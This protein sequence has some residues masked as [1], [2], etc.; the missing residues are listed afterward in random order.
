MTST[1][2]H[3]ALPQLADACASASPDAGDPPAIARRALLHGTGA[4]IF[5]LGLPELA[6]GT[7]IVAVRVWP[8]ADYTRVTLESD[9]NLIGQH[10]VTAD[11]PRLVIDVD[12]LE[13]NNTLRELV[14]KVLPDDPHIARV[15]LGQSQPNRVRIVLDLKQVSRP[16][17]FA[18]APIAPYRHRLVFDLYP[19]AAPGAA[20]DAVAA[21]RPPLAAASP[22]ASSPGPAV[23]PLGSPRPPSPAGADTA[24]AASTPLRGGDATL[25][26]SDDD[27]MSLLAQQRG[28]GGPGA[29][30]ATDAASVYAQPGASSIASPIA[31]PITSPISPPLTP[32]A[33]S[34]GLDPSAPPRVDA[35]ATGRRRGP[36]P[37]PAAADPAATAQRA[38]PRRPVRPA[39]RL[40][41]VAIDPG[42]GGEDPGA[43]GPTGLREKDVVLAIGRQLA[44]RINAR[45]GMRAVLTRD[46][47]YFVPLFE[48]VRKARGA[49]ADLFMSIHADAFIRPH[50]RGASVFALS[51]SGASS[52]TARW[53]AQRENLS[54]AIGGINIVD[55]RDRAFLQTLLDMSTTRQIKD[56]MKLG[57]ELLGHIGR[58]GQLHTGRVEQAGFAVLKAPDIP[59]ILVE[60]AFISNPLEEK[61]LRSEAYR[62]SLVNA[63]EGG[64]T[65][66]FARNPPLARGGT[67]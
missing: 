11:P 16:Q 44:E 53:M 36:A 19:S 13:L 39:A 4:L 42:H 33:A 15:R 50:A 14:A 1:P 25:P 26:R 67:L 6:H 21:L 49:Q 7:T 17:V 52:A 40:L 37:P 65:R 58:V 51:Q 24:P 3:P 63:M 9:T 35:P 28:P 38:D 8:A 30:G 54:D 61:R 34:P 62:S 31:S 45:P 10:F 18:L 43:T 60:T 57:S 32:P 47:D 22:T 20:A 55:S 29:D 46:A 59:S 64:I 48:R 2:R 41:I 56:S 66:Y 23:P 5:S 12:G 27:V